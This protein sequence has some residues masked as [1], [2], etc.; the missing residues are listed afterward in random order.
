MKNW[1]T[2]S[3]AATWPNPP[4]ETCQLLYGYGNPDLS[5]I[6]VSFALREN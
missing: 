5:G 2:D 1:T 6:G 3:R 4:P